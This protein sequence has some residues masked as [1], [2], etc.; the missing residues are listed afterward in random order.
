MKMLSIAL[1]PTLRA[2]A[3]RA[4]AGCVAGM[5]LVAQV[6][7]GP[8]AHGP[9]GEHLDAPAAAA[10]GS[11]GAFLEARSELFELVAK[12]EVG[13]LLVMIDR[14]N[15]NDPVLNA[16][17]EVESGSAKAKARFQPEQGG[18]VVDD[19]VFLKTIAAPG[20]HA[21]VFTVV[22]GQESDLLDG[23]LFAAGASARHAASAARDSHGHDNGHDHGHDHHDHGHGI[24]RA[25]IAGAIV[26]GLAVVAF[27]AWRHGR[28]AG[29]QAGGKP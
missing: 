24:E 15:T 12:L 21:L 18:Y 14:Y 10:A 5:L 7:A 20:Q 3:R 27:V 1:I 23:R 6:H 13:R 26:L 19:A 22:A 29:G 28:K 11:G 2:A 25:G 4:L 8:G 16:Q 9:D 17:V